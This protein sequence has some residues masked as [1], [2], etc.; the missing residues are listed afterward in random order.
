MKT[1]EKGTRVAVQPEAPTDEYRTDK[2][3]DLPV[4]DE[5]AEATKGGLLLPAVQKCREAAARMN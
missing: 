4:N 3:P 2:L 1:E 5:P